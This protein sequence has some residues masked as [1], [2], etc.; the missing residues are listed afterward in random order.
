MDI[1]TLCLGV[2]T[3]GDASGYEIKRLFED[4]FSHFYVAG[5]GSIYPA[6]AELTRHGH[7]TASSVTQ[8]K[9]PAKKV[10]HLT[11]SGRQR[12][13]RA[14]EETYPAHRVRSDFM[15]LAAF[16]HLQSRERMAQVLDTRLVDIAAQLAL[17]DECVDARAE[18]G[19]GVVFAA[20][21]AR[22]VLEA[23]E[24]YIRQHRTTLL[25]ALTNQESPT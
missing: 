10:Y 2:L 8:Q 19:P 16:A 1:K 7:V 11:E 23:G 12:F 13:I 18:G 14:L 21:Y 24:R 3:L 20:G 17:I 5:F 4:S 9:R 15:V 25:Q 6:L 22:A